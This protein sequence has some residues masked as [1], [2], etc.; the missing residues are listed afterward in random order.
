[1]MAGWRNHFSQL[2]NVHRV[3]YVRQT[4]IHTSEPLV[5]EPSAFDVEMASEKLK[6]KHKSQGTDKIPAQLIIVGDRTIHSEIHKL[7]NSIWSKKE[8]PEEWKESIIVS[9][10]NKG[11]KTG[12][13]NYKRISLL[14]STF[15]ILSNILLSRLGC[16][17]YEG[18]SLL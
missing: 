4:E 12:C 13:S 8:L 2:L 16:S 9:N 5:P 1:M 11:D 17:N 18:I 3:N 7:I 10:Y 14:S 15:K 6:K